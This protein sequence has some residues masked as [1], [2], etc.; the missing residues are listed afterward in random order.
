MS[1]AKKPPPSHNIAFGLVVAELRRGR[2]MSQD[3]LSEAS[4]FD[5][6]SISLLE[7]GLRSPTLDT[8]ICLCRALEIPYSQLAVLIEAK[9]EQLHAQEKPQPR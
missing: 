3:K 7:R 1:K 6:T 8:V 2:R 4:N 5:R 9:L